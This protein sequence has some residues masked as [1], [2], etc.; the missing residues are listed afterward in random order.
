MPEYETQ[1]FSPNNTFQI[2]RVSTSVAGVRNMKKE[3]QEELL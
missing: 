3:K 1:Y 2:F